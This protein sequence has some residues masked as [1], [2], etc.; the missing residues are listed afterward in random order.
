M[1]STNV[2]VEYDAVYRFIIE[3]NSPEALKKF[4]EMTKDKKY[5]YRQTQLENDF[6]RVRKMDG[7][8]AILHNAC[9]ENYVINVPKATLKY[10][11]LE[12]EEIKEKKGG[13]VRM[14]EGIEI[15]APEELRKFEKIEEKYLL[16]Y[17]Y[18]IKKRVLFDKC[19][20]SEEVTNYD[21][22]R[23]ADKLPKYLNNILTEEEKRIRIYI[24]ERSKEN[25][26]EKR[27]EINKR[28]YR[29]KEKKEEGKGEEG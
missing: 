12:E 9:S 24:R 22:I 3:N 4:V 16:P 7:R 2:L 15:E 27:K 10:F 28:R 5:I 20:E 14:E 25:Y 11:L 17:Q 18:K 21:V 29:K 23:Y 1:R 8:Y 13:V 26:A 6:I 19:G